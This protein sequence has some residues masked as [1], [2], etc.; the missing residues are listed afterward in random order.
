MIKLLKNLLIIIIIVIAIFFFRDYFKEAWD[1]IE[2]KFW[3]CTSPLTYSISKLDKD[4]GVSKDTFIQRI[5]D[6]EDVWEKSIGKDLFQYVETGGDISVSLIFDTRQETTVTLQKL[7]LSVDTTRASYD[8]LKSTY[9]SLK[10]SYDKDRLV[11]EKRYAEFE[12][13]RIAYE[14]AV[15]GTKRGNRNTSIDLESERRY[16]IEESEVLNNMQSALNQKVADMNSLGTT[17]NDLAK[18][19]NINVATYNQIGRESMGEFEEGVYRYVDGKREID[20]YQFEDRAMLVRVLAHELG[21]AIG[22]DH[23]A[24]DGSIMYRLNNS[25]S[26]VPSTDDVSALKNVCKI[27]L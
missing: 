2:T 27:E 16:L 19:L 5:K 8:K 6:A 11:F 12:S 9:E 26:L 13:R 22:M 23:V 4:F 21:H 3:P 25:K 24:E 18:K 14:K 7:G 15:S 17:L 10:I 1:V 20:I